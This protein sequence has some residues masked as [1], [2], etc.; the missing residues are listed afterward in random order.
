MP[1]RGTYAP[2]KRLRV[3]L[4][5]AAISTLLFIVLRWNTP[6]SVDEPLPGTYQYF[7]EKDFLSDTH[8]FGGVS[9]VDSRFVPARHLGPDEVREALDDLLQSFAATMKDLKAETWLSH[10]ALLGWWWNG[11]L[12]PWDT[13]LDFQMTAT[14]IAKLASTANMTEYSYKGRHS[15][16]TRKYLLD[17][18]PHHS[19]ASSRDVA[20]KIDGRWIDTMSGKFI[21]ITA[22]HEESPEILFC[23]DGHRYKVRLR[24]L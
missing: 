12:L 22:V 6:S 9:H 8:R 17:I 19:I 23:K 15:Q 7:T 21:D 24:F 10:G 16:Q 3:L 14:G 4:W 13:D 18:N 5:L 11:K 20:N 2:S 1:H